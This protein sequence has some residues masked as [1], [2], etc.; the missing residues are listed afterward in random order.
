MRSL[1]LFEE[2]C[3]RITSAAIGEPSAGIVEI[4]EDQ[5]QWTV[6]GEFKKL[7]PLRKYSRSDGREVYVSTASCQVEQF[8]TRASR[9]HADLSAIPQWL[10]FTPLRKH[11]EQWTKV[12]VWSSGLGTV[13]AYLGIVIGLRMYL[14]SKR[15]R[16]AQ[17]SSRLLLSW[18][19]LCRKA[20]SIFREPTLPATRFGQ[21]KAKQ[22]GQKPNTSRHS[23]D[24][25][26]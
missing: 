23:Y 13:F 18:T 15:Y 16:Y 25:R 4:L 12:V 20:V 3:G 22:P 21:H 8:T 26:E 19:L 1:R 7:L 10:Y 5:D 11:T 14:P 6:P 9:F 2:K 17:G 24:L